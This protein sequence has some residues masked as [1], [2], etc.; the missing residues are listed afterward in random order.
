V[1]REIMVVYESSLLENESLEGQTTGFKPIVD[2]M[3]DPA[4]EM[5]LTVSEEK[6][7]ARPLWDKQ[8]FILNC[9]EYIKVCFFR[10]CASS[11]SNL[12]NSTHSECH[13]AFCVHL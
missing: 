12:I 9:L 13:R 4:V 1:L 3:L 2:A 11:L 8:V 6:Q 5:C 10:A 7:K